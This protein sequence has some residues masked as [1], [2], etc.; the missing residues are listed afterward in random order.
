MRS[1]GSKQP[2]ESYYVAFDFTNVI[3]EATI[4][5][6]TVV[7]VDEEGTVVTETLTTV[8]SQLIVSPIVNVWVKGGATGKKY[9]I[10]CKIGTDSTPSE[11]YELDA[12][13]PVREE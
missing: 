4:T 6:A 1:F 8:G 5:T 2:Y 10:T 3:G 12:W 9:K 7:V 11:L 13:L